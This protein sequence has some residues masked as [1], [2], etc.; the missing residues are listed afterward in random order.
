MK[1]QV[2]EIKTIKLDNEDNFDSINT[3]DTMYGLR[4]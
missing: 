4:N 3:D 1:P 2:D